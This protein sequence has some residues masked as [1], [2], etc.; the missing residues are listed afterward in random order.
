MNCRVLSE[1]LAHHLIQ[2]GVIEIPYPDGFDMEDVA[3]I[4][5][6]YLQAWFCTVDINLDYPWD[7]D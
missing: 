7:E 5:E 6:D 4:I 1:N 3:D 2:T